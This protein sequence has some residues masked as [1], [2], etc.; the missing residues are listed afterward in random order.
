M[1][2]VAVAI[3]LTAIERRELESLARAHKTGQAMARRARIVLAAAAGL[4]NKAICAEV[5]ADANTVSKWRRRF[6]EHRLDG[7]LDEPRPGT[8]RRI[9]DGE[10]AETIRLSDSP[11]RASA[12]DW[13]DPPSRARG[14]VAD[15]QP[16]VNPPIPPPASWPDP[17]RSGRPEPRLDWPTRR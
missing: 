7:L 10:I 14:G 16:R 5:G 13:V 3:D 6:A 17:P 15:S 8:P 12:E 4:E 9:G 2:K 1:G 11:R